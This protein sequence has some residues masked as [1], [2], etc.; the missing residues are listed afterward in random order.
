MLRR[1]DLVDQFEDL[2]KQEIKNHQNHLLATNVSLNKFEETLY[3]IE[4]NVQKF[5][6]QLDQKIW[7]QKIKRDKEKESTEKEKE[8]SKKDFNKWKNHLCFF[9]GETQTRIERLEKDSCKKEEIEKIKKNISNFQNE[10][11][12]TLADMRKMLDQAIS[13]LHQKVLTEN[14]KLKDE[15]STNPSHLAQLKDSLVKKIN[16]CYVDSHGLKKEV[17][18]AR[19]ASFINEKKIENLYTLN[20]R[21]GKKIDN[22]RES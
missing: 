1:R 21:L 8:N 11:C 15:L 4:K 18:A 20:E 10:T 3:Q 13:S 6:S 16:E 7:D 5:S 19:K 14:K 12:K 2:V 9:E 22:M 17:Q